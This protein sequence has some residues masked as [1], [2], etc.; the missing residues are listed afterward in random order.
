MPAYVAFL[1]AINVGGHIVKMDRLRA[2]F[3]RMGLESVSTFIASGNVL[4]EAE[5][6]DEQTLEKRI[7]SALEAELG[8]AVGVFLRTPEELVAVSRHPPFSAEEIASAGGLYVC[9]LPSAPGAAVRKAVAALDTPVDTLRIH[10]RELYWRVAE[11]I[12]ATEV[13][14]A[15]LGKALGMPMTMR[16]MNTVRRIIAR[17]GA[18]GTT[19]GGAAKGP[20]GEKRGG[21]QGT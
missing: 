12:S 21:R 13:K 18:A 9:F 5:E 1:R 19:A 20:G 8:Y 15:V 11:R 14:D 10:G 4:F 17:I 6:E 16:N 7:E 2:L 3:E